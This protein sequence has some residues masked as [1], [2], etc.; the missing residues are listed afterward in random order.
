MRLTPSQVAIAKKIRCATRRICETIKYHEG[1]I[2]IWKIIMKKR[3]SRASQTEKKEAKKKV[4][5]PPSS[6]DAPPAPTGFTQ[7]DKSESMGFQDTKKNV[8]KN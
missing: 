6:L 7:M 3:T 5:T 2:S 8:W 4:W 1:G